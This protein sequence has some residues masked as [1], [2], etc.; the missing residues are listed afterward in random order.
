MNQVETEQF[1]RDDRNDLL[2]LLEMRFGGVPQP[3]QEQICR[4][5]DLNELQRLIIAACNA[6]DWEVFMEEL[7]LGQD[8]F[9]LTGERFNPVNQHGKEHLCNG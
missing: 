6:A 7:Q 2:A 5:Q 3:V 4:L 9:K 1:V 8:S